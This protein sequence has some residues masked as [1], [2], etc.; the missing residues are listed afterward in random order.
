M[1]VVRNG[2]HDF[3]LSF[4][5]RALLR[6]VLVLLLT[7][8]RTAVVRRGHVVVGNIRI[9][10]PHVQLQ[11]GQVSIGIRQVHNQQ[12]AQEK[13]ER[14]E[15]EK[16]PGFPIAK[17]VQQA[18]HEQCE[19]ML[20]VIRERGLIYL[21]RLLLCGQTD[22]HI[23]H[24]RW[25]YR[26]HVIADLGL[27]QLAPCFCLRLCFS[28]VL[29]SDEDLL[30]SGHGYSV[31]LDVKLLSVLVDVLEEALERG[32][33]IERQLEH[34]LFAHVVQQASVWDAT[35]HQIGHA[36]TVEGDRVLLLNSHAVAQAELPLEIE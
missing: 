3:F 4:D 29:H 25:N 35:V 20:S 22:I 28:G 11:Q 7:K 17:E 10:K 33:A 36:R 18:L 16:D 24:L 12:T 23:H 14:Y 19:E 9:V 6:G 30:K 8:S 15:I 32:S 34:D 27:Q 21:H 13:Q 2:F 31:R 26:V 1:D 5:V